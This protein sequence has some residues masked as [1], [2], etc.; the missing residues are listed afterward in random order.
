MGLV[1]G[2]LSVNKTERERLAIIETKIDNMTKSID[3][4]TDRCIREEE[5]REKIGRLVAQ[6]DQLLKD[7]I[8]KTERN[9]S[10][11]KEW[12]RRKTIACISAITAITVWVVDHIARFFGV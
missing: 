2:G 6:N 8:E 3:K 4:I 1:K 9:S 12:S 7:H 11:N 10:E 5:D